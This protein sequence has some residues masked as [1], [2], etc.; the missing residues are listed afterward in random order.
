[1][2]ELDKNPALKAM[3]VFRKAQRTLD[4]QSSAFFQKANLTPTQF[5][6]LEVLYSK[7]S[8]RINKLI[9][10]LLATSGNMTVVLKNMERNGWISR[11]QDAKD[12]RACLVQLTPEGKALIETIL[13]EHIKRVEALFSVLTETEQKQLI[14]LLK[15]FKEL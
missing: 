3:V 9:G 2:N 7:G 15:K 10:S 4:A 14:T 11:C 1:M 13:P 12:K 6:V 5:S 8:M